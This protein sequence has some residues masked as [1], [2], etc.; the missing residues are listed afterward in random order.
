MTEMAQTEASQA[1]ESDSPLVVM[2]GMMG[3][4]MSALIEP[5]RVGL[6][7]SVRRLTVTVK[8]DELGR[9]EQKLV[10]V[11]YMTD[12]AKLDLAVQAGFGAPAGG[13][14]GTGSG[15]AARGAGATP[16]AGGGGRP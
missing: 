12:P 13:A 16:P 6:Q 10:V 2:A 4:F 8:W 9:P 11:T 1:S 14:P 3:G 5:I 15:G 7:E